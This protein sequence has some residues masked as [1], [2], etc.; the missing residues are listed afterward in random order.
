M[1]KT[2][3][4]LGGYA[5]KIAAEYLEK[6]GLKVQKLNHRNNIGEIDIV[7]KD[8]DVFVFVEVKAKTGDQFGSPL[9]MVGYRKQEKL[10]KL[11]KSYFVQNELDESLYRIDVIAIDFSQNQPKIDWIKSAVEE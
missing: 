5:E 9:D 10:R 6:K 2:S 7:A 1:N 11:A 8:G 4:K 3:K